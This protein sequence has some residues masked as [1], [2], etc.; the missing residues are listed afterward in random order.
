MGAE[1]GRLVDETG[2]THLIA[3]VSLWIMMIGLEI[4]AIKRYLNRK[5]AVATVES[6]A[7]PVAAGPANAE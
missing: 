7:E 5:K 3:D 6:A 2:E 1:R 4:V